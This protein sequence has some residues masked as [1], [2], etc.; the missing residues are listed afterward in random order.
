MDQSVSLPE[1]FVFE[2]TNVNCMTK[3]PQSA[4]LRRGH[5]CPF[6]TSV[7]PVFWI[8]PGCKTTTINDFVA[9]SVSIEIEQPFFASVYDIVTSLRNHQQRVNT[10]GAFHLPK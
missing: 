7:C 1:D 6:M 4:V 2:S 10:Q 3:S 5:P 9:L 8:P